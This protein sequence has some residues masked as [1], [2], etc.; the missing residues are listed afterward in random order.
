MRVMKTNKPRVQLEPELEEMVIGWSPER[1]RALAKKLNRWS[2]QLFIS[3]K[4]LE[5]DRIHRPPTLRR[6]SLKIAAAN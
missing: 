4:I 2:K 6:V 3:A 1:R 5:R